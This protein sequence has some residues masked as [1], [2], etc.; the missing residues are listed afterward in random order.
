MC[1]TILKE[2]QHFLIRQENKLLEAQLLAL[3]EKEESN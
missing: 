2:Y 1:D 3:L